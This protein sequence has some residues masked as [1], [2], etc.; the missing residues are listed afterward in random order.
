MYCAEYVEYLKKLDGIVLHAK[1]K[2]KKDLIPERFA[3]GY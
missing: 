1:N 3:L 2:D